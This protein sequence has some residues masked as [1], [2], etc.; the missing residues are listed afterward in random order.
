MGHV[1]RIS[2]DLVTG[3]CLADAWA[4]GQEPAENG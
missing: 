3:Y 1:I 2:A 4:Y